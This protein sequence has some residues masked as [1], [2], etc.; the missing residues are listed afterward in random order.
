MCS[1]SEEDLKFYPD[2]D[3]YSRSIMFK[4]RP[5]G[6]INHRILRLYDYEWCRS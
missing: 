2:I 4:I 3:I 1:C 5:K 6:K